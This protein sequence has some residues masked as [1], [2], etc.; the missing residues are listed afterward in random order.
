MKWRKWNYVLHRDIGY[1]CVGLTIIY[2]LSGIVV[3]HT[4]HSFNPSY[5]IEKS[6]QVVSE[7]QYSGQ[8]DMH[9][10]QRVLDEL[11]ESGGFKNVAMLSPTTIRIFVE[12]NTI[13]VELTSGKVSQEKVARKPVLFEVNFLHL[14][15]YKKSWTWFADLYAVALAFL[16]ISGLLMIR[17]KNAKRSIVLTSIGIII[18]IAFMLAI[19]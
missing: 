12:G 9:Y 17:G 14:N 15:K 7:L 2:A 6:Q 13:D 19:L 8:P 5:S 11:Q 10:I 3:N 4:S 16:A 1:L 18:P